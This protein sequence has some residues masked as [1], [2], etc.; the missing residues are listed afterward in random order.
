M[1]SRSV[2]ELCARLNQPDASFRLT[3]VED[4]IRRMSERIDREA[5]GTRLSDERTG[6]I[7]EEWGTLTRS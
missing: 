7:L 1:F 2:L 6:Q 4:R 5:R 3:D